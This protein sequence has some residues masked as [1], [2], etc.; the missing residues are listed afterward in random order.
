MQKFDDLL[1]FVRVVESG[2]F[3]GA[4]RRLGV[5]PA[6]VSRKIQNLE[7]RLGLPLLR[8]TTR[9]L[10][11]T[12]AGRGVFEAAARGVAAMEEAEASVRARQETPS[13]LLRIVAP[14]A[15]GL[16]RLEP[17]LR[18]F[19]LAFPDVRVSLTL[20]NEAFDLVAYDFDVALRAGRAEDTA[21]IVRPVVRGSF[22]VVASPDFVA[23][24]GSPDSPRDLPR[25]PVAALTGP[26]FIGRPEPAGPTTYVFT[27]GAESVT[28]KLD[29]VV[30]SNEAIA[31]LP[32]ALHGAGPAVLV[33][34]LCREHI[35][36]GD[37][38][39][40]LD[41]WRIDAERELSLVYAQK[42]TQDPKIRAFVDFM[43]E[44]AH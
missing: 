43:M 32:H 27:R 40:L 15:F 35:E 25:F 5:P 34:I 10:S 14:Y 29:P 33:E 11:V 23:R 30:S 2:S 13:G 7:A 42:A 26:M 6:T 31:L 37:L 41:D 24:A 16:L 3:I 4:A 17:M 36:K 1:A 18:E 12:D 38:V 39:V 9:R 28:I 8:R 44:R 20:T 19:R 21:Y 22:V